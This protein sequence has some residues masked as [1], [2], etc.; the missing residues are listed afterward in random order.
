MPSVRSSTKRF[1]PHALV[2]TSVVMVLP[3]LAVSV[4][5]TSSRPWL[6]V[7]TVLLAMAMSVA[8]ASAGAAIWK[9]RPG[10]KDILFG[11]LMLWGWLRRLRAERRLDKVQKILGL[12]A[13]KLYELEVPTK[14]GFQVAVPA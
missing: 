8:G 6:V 10:S 11:D 2:A 13:A 5:D 12:N 9:R 3:A 4:I 14:A 1:L 7:L